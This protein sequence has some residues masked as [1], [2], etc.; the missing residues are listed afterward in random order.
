[1]AQRSLAAPEQRDVTLPAHS[2]LSTRALADDAVLFEAQVVHRL[3]HRL[4]DLLPIGP[5]LDELINVLE[6][7]L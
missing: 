5:S 7:D 6:A 3:V 1:M 2:G 4:L